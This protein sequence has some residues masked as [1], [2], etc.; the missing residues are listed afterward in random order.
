MNVC[1]PVFSLSFSNV[2][3]WCVVV[4]G[5]TRRG[6]CLGGAR[7]AKVRQSGGELMN[8]TTS[9]TLSLTCRELAV[10]TMGMN[11]DLEFR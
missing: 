5:A 1:R 6:C 4:V 11:D 3:S 8:A 7:Y 10:F 9:L 2:A